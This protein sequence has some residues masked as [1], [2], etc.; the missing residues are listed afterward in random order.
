M[1]EHERAAP[2]DGASEKTMTLVG[3]LT[4]LR[5]RLFIVLGSLLVGAVVGWYGV[6]WVLD[7]FR[8][9]VG[10]LAFYSPAE[11]FLTRIRIAV[12]LGAVITIPVM[13][14]QVWLFVMPALF[15]H[16]RKLVA[17]YVP[18]AF[19]LFVAGLLL[20]FYVIYPLAVEFLLRTGAADAQ[21]AISFSEHFSFFTTMILPMAIAF[22]LPL[23]MHA[24]G[25][26][27]ILSP[28]IFQRRRR[29]VI[30]WAAVVAAMITPP[31]VVS[32]LLLAVP[33]ILLFEV[34]IH[35]ARRAA[36]TRARELQERNAGGGEET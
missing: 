32:M 25:R 14:S 1:T 22:Q 7:L 36:A 8:E 12:T 29:H 27:E 33:I 10:T 35:L 17:R 30:F 28:L 6:D 13:L 18:V 21:L 15:A 9:R 31:D 5:M 3:H 4:E 19:A 23:L 16:E 2:V 11:P 24:A 26:L 20:G 34:G